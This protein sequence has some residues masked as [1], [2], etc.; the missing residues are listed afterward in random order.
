MS[1]NIDVHVSTE[2]MAKSVRNVS[3]H[4]LGTTTAVIAMQ[5]ATI[6]AEQ[7]AADQISQEVTI[8]FHRLIMSQVAQKAAKAKAIVDS[9][10]QEL[11]HLSKSLMQVR[12][13]MER[14]FHR[15]AHRYGKL[16]KSLNDAL[17][18]RVRE[19]DSQAY[20]LPRVQFNAMQRRVSGFAVFPSI[21]QKDSVAY[22]QI[23][24]VNKIRNNV[25]KSIDSISNVLSK[26]QILQSRMSFILENNTIK[27]RL[28]IMA[29]VLLIESD[30]FAVELSRKS[31]YTPDPVGFTPQIQSE[32]RQLLMQSHWIGVDSKLK[33][34]VVEKCLQRVSS[35]PVSERVRKKIVELS[36]QV[37]W[38]VPQGVSH[39]I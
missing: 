16:F 32:I 1:S 27:Q 23:M 29:P 31:L 8:G 4:V 25:K 3:R 18:Q 12:D 20:A 21:H 7:A 34:A 26:G 37:D 9:K 6:L 30:D 10:Q 33:S 13:Q 36:S 15:I 14:D 22:G 24:S 5:T 2:P 11:L 28:S 19:L 17:A 38:Q 35:L 39:G